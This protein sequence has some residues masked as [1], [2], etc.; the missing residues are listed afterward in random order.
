[1]IVGSIAGLAHGRT[2]ATQ[3][4]D[5]VDDAR[6]LAHDEPDVR[7]PVGLPKLEA[8]QLGRLEPPF[9]DEGGD[10]EPGDWCQEPR[11]R[12]PG[13][14]V[15]PRRYDVTTSVARRRAEPPTARA[16]VASVQGLPAQ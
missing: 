4:F 13:G 3:D 10:A 16:Q 6:V 7:A 15:P 1:M 12:E 11:R 2:R 9:D 14:G 8:L 5:P